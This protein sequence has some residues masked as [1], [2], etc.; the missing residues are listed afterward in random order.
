MGA[1][2]WNL[3]SF[4]KGYEHVAGA[5]GRL[6]RIPSASPRRRI[7]IIVQRRKSITAAFEQAYAAGA[8]FEAE[9]RWSLS[10]NITRSPATT[11]RR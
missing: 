7:R 5:A 2:F 11:T 10:R 4:E 9:A 6:A 8:L 3:G 1:A